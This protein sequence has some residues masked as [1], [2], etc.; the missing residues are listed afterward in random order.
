MPISLGYDHF[1]V[2]QI[3]AQLSFINV[4]ALSRM[5]L[6]TL[7]SSTGCPEHHPNGAE[8]SVWP[9]P[10]LSRSSSQRNLSF[11]KPVARKWDWNKDS[12][13]PFLARAL[14]LCV[15]ETLVTL[16]VHRKG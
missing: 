6:S 4:K 11:K 13:V 14:I 16:L 9:F 8:L 7:N 2:L 1:Q 10:H 12:L 15:Y 5:V 3:R